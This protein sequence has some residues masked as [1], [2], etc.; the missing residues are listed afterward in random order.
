M[1]TDY[2]ELNIKKT[3]V[4]KKEARLIRKILR[5]VYYH[6]EIFWYESRELVAEFFDFKL[7]KH[8]INKKNL[9]KS[10]A[11]FLHYFIYFYYHNSENLDLKLEIE[12]NFSKSELFSGK[13]Y[14]G[15]YRFVSIFLNWCIKNEVRIERTDIYK[16]ILFKEIE[17]QKLIDKLIRV[18]D[19]LEK[20]IES[21]KN[22][23]KHRKYYINF[24]FDQIEK[25]NYSNI[26]L[27]ELVKKKIFNKNVL[28]IYINR[29]VECFNRLIDKI[30]VCKNSFIVSEISTIL[31]ELKNLKSI[32]SKEKKENNIFL[33]KIDQIIR[34]TLFYKR[35]WFFK[36]GEKIENLK[37]MSFEMPIKREKVDTFRRRFL[38]NPL[39]GIFDS[40][41]IDLKK[42]MQEHLSNYSVWQMVRKYTLNVKEEI[43]IECIQKYPIEIV[44]YIDEYI[45]QSSRCFESFID[46]ELFINNWKVAISFLGDDIKKV[47]DCISDKYYVLDSI[48]YYTYYIKIIMSVQMKIK[49]A[50]EFYV[51]KSD[52]FDISKM[53]MFLF[54]K[55]KNNDFLINVIFSLYV[56]LYDENTYNLRNRIMHGML[57]NESEITNTKYLLYGIEMLATSLLEKITGEK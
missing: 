29:I 20:I 39:K 30:K 2:L 56:Y 22:V 5:V 27:I 48:N 17:R 32:L 31:K 7:I 35:Q 1:F 25:V 49:Q 44:E 3:K 18:T 46:N 23:K 10:V 51:G 24:C 28:K 57:L 19:E 14:N 8:S 47:L 41:Y 33:E 13:I 4:S 45:G 16:V 38:R 52:S 50:Y 15:A 26:V 54:I 55:H 40:M 9:N 34:A 11:Y 36:T 37:P 53:L 12:K 6:D 43:Y 42:T 21:D